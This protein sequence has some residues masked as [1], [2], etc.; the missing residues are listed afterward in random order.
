M[1]DVRRGRWAFWMTVA[2][3]LWGL[4][5]VA[6]AFFFPLYSSGLTLTEVNGLGALLPM[7]LPALLAVLIGLAL[8]R[9]CSRGSRS[10][11][12]VAGVLLGLLAAFC[13]VTSIGA[14][15]LPVVL[16]LAIAAKLTPSSPG[17]AARLGYLG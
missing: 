6:G 5:L 17:G 13:V 8:H 15:V 14:F 1:D 3:F 4:A 10:G 11:G 9:K 2:A 7:G 12:Y 16:L